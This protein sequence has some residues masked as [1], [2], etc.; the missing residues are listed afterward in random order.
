MDLVL[1]YAG[2]LV[3]GNHHFDG[4]DTYRHNDWFKGRVKDTNKNN[5]NHCM[6]KLQ[7]VLHYFLLHY[8]L[9]HYFLL[10]Y[11][12]LHYFLHYFFCITSSALLLANKPS[13]MLLDEPFSNIDSQVRQ[14]L[15]RL[16]GRFGI[17]SNRKK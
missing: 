13:I 5:L 3:T 8:F 12:L 9:L 11:F 6:D 15:V 1:A 17:S 10:H 16:S 7:G 2:L 4:I 14:H